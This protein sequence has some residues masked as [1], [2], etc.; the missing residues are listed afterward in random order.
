MS[1]S[2]LAIACG[3]AVGAVLR[4]GLNQGASA[5]LGGAFPCG[6]LAANVLG[7][8]LMGVLVA[9]F[10]HLWDPGQEIKAFLAVGVLGAFTTFSTFS[11]DAVLLAS[12]GAYG[13]AALYIL[14][15][16][17]LGI[18]ALLAGMWMIRS[19]VL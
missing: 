15:S 3:G 5:W 17:A 1:A 10:A 16:V 14:L 2:V 6:I 19:F 18:S 7:S 12:R 13:L 8:F 4:H 11:L 9:V